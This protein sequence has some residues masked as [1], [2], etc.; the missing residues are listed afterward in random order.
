MPT[1][2]IEYA[3]T[4]LDPLNRNDDTLNDLLLSTAIASN[5]RRKLQRE[6][7]KTQTAVMFDDKLLSP[8][9]SRDA[10]ARNLLEVISLQ[11]D[12]SIFESDLRVLASSLID[13]V[14]EPRKA[15]LARAIE[16]RAHKGLPLLCSI[17]ISIWHALRLG[18][19][20]DTAPYSTG[21]EG[22]RAIDSADIAISILT[23]REKTYE[24]RAIRE[25]LQYIPDLDSNRIRNFYFAPGEQYDTLRLDIEAFTETIMKEVHDYE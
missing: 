24:D 6:G 8:A 12:V 14:S 11:P 23:T 18:I 15:K 2:S 22:F 9:R 10:E 16:K 20:G 5:I 21:I 19:F 1:V 13:V 4:V 25:N 7:L 17:D 3:H